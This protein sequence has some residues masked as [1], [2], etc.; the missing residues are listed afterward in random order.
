[1]ATLMRIAQKP[2]EVQDYNWQTSQ[3]GTEC[4]TAV[5]LDRQHWRS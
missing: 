3:N 2:S 1:M 4:L 5:G